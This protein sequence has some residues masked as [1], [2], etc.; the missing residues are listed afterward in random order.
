VVLRPGF[1][2]VV[3]TAPR[4]TP[5]SPGGTA[6]AIDALPGL[7]RD[8]ATDLVEP[9]APTGVVAEAVA[10]VGHLDVLA[11][12][13]ARSAP[14]GALAGVTTE[15]LDGHEAVAARSAILLA[16]ALASRHEDGRAV[17]RGAG[18]WGRC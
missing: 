7:A 12:N 5:S 10:R 13:P 9:D 8:V 15:V 17:L 18:W 6:A 2:L 1:R 11:A 4:T 14:D 16:R 3:T